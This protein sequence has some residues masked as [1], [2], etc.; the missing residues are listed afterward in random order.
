MRITLLI[1]SMAPL[2]IGAASPSNASDR[3]SDTA[4][5][6][7]DGINATAPLVAERSGRTTASTS[8][9][10]EAAFAARLARAPGLH[11]FEDDYIRCVV[12]RALVYATATSEP[13]SAV[14]EAATVM[15]EREREGLVT[16][17]RLALWGVM[18]VSIQRVDDPAFARA[19][20]ARVDLIDRAVARVV[21]SRVVHMRAM[22]ALSAPP[23]SSSPRQ[24]A[25]DP[26]QLVDRPLPLEWRL[27][28]IV[29]RL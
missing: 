10:S 4:K 1:A 9:T 17:Y 23:R 29:D 15:C 27:K 20:K 3:L 16:G 22:D 24:A 6:M 25:G 28:A 12:K 8:G 26:Y 13:A 7:V 21:S 5:S 11:V 2:V 14:A 19:A 18:Q